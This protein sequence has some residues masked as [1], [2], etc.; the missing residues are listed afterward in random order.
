MAGEWGKELVAGAKVLREKLFNMD[1][2]SLLAS[3]MDELIQLKLLYDYIRKLE[4]EENA[5]D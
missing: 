3:P 2:E 5:N 4:E 1:E